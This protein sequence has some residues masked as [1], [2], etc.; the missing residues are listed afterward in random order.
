VV[1]PQPVEREREEQWLRD[2]KDLQA[3]I[4]KSVTAIDEHCSGFDK[5]PGPTLHD[6]EK[7]RVFYQT[8]SSRVREEWSINDCPM[9]S[10]A[11]REV[12]EMSVCRKPPFQKD[13]DRNFQ[14]T[15]I[16]LSV[17]DHIK[18][19][20]NNPV[21]AIVSGDGGFVDNFKGI[22]SQ[23]G[24]RII[25]YRTLEDVTAELQTGFEQRIQL[26][27]QKDEADAKAA[28]STMLDKIRTHVFNVSFKDPLLVKILEK[29]DVEKLRILKVTLPYPL[30]EK[31][32]DFSFDVRLVLTAI[33]EDCGAF[34]GSWANEFL[35]SSR[36]PEV[37]TPDTTQP[38]RFLKE[39]NVS[40][41]GR[42][43][44]G[45]FCVDE[46]GEAYDKDPFALGR[47]DE[48]DIVR[49]HAV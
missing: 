44:N 6:I 31:P 17:V 8:I 22:D 26:D 7:L 41:K 13:K 10:R 48:M 25:P 37:K 2:V 29:K 5:I 23:N 30:T 1:I 20:G 42:R 34:S 32:F 43:V 28:L 47:F 15:V 16:Y 39:V 46:F 40:A 36:G 3:S 38:Q 45:Q 49:R 27:I 4:H 19:L 35:K 11:L 12:F 14:D 24:V 21:S 33:V 9:T 18:S